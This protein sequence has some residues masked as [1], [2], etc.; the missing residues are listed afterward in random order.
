MNVRSIITKGYENYI[1]LD[2]W[3]KQTQF[4]AKQSQ[5]R[6]FARKNEVRITKS[7]NSSGVA[8]CLL[9]R[10]G[11]ATIWKGAFEKTKPIRRPLPEIR[12]T[13][14]EILNKTERCIWK[15]KANVKMGNMALI[16]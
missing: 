14:L 3:W 11:R 8:G 5:S 2:T 1:G 13:K 15:N 16:Q 6:G 9:P 12:N 7:D 10:V 4:K